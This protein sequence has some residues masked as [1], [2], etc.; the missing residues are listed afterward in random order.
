MSNNFEIVF[1]DL[2]EEF[3]EKVELYSLPDMANMEIRMKIF[4]MNRL[5][6]RALRMKNRKLALLNTFYLGQ[7]IESDDVFKYVA[8][9]KLSSYYYVAAVR[10]YYIFEMSPEQIMRTRRTTLKN[11]RDLKAQEFGSLV[12]RI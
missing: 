5:I 1:N 3:P 11:I 12:G 4:A 8:K 9:Q 10:T 7:M 6:K 2:W